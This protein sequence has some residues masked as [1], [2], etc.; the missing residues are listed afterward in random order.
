[1]PPIPTLSEIEANR[2]LIE[3][4]IVETPT[5]PWP[6]RV[7]GERLGP[8]TEVYVKLETLQRTGTFKP[9]G[10]LSNMLRLSEDEKARG[11][12]AISAGN[13]AIAVSYAA[14]IL[15][16]SAKVVMARSSAP[17]R[18][19]RSEA[20]GGEIALVD[21]IAEGFALVQR[22]QNE[23]GRTFV[24]PFEGNS[25]RLGTATL[26]LEFARAV[27]RL[28]AVIIPI[29]G[30]GLIAGAAIGI[31]AVQPNCKVYGVEPEGSKG[32]SD[33]LAAGRPLEEVAHD[34]FAD[35]LGPPFHT[36]G[37]FEVCRDFVDDIAIVT[38]DDLRRNMALI[39]DE[40]KMAVEPA[41]A[42]ATAALLGPL[43]GRLKGKRIGV[44]LCGTNIDFDLY[45]DEVRA[46]TAP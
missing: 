37:T 14:S 19:A 16:V 42:A 3:P 32:M 8:E 27:D 35:S 39:F 33:S 40:L 2:A 6:G 43:A 30:G 28:D 29:G 45:V 10:A 4:Y 41:G 25:T 38:D 17:V 23:E 1:M 36:Q 22:F 24:H 46:A 34:S 18:V 7:M 11:V 13:H 26:G 5:V 15:S 31:K 20:Y 21:D 44:L 12:T 9:R